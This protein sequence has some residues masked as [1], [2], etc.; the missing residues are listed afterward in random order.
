M[1]KKF[2]TKVFLSEYD[3]FG[4]LIRGEVDI[5]LLDFY[6]QPTDM[7]FCLVYLTRQTAEAIAVTLDHVFPGGVI[8]IS[9]ATVKLTLR[10][11]RSKEVIELLRVELEVE[12]ITA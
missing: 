3:I 7:H 5:A 10:G 1:G 8:E 9:F 11:K 12:V 6:Q 2:K 4:A